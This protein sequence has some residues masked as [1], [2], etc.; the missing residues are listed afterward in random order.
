MKS[1]KKDRILKSNLST[2]LKRFSST[3]LIS[4]L[5]KEYTDSISRNIKLS[6]IFDNHILFR[7][8][9]SE[10]KIDMAINNINSHGFTAPLLVYRYEDKYEV[11]SSREY[12]FAS[13]RLNLESIPCSILNI[14]EEELLFLLASKLMDTKNSNIIELSLILDKLIKKYGYTQKE[15]ATLLNQSRSQITNIRKLINLPNFIL[16][17]VSDDNISFGHARAL[18]TL[19]G[20][21]IK[22]VLKSIK[23]NHLSVRESEEL[24]YDLKNDLKI[25]TIKRQLIKNN[26]LKNAQVTNTKITLV[27]KSK[28]QRDKYLKIN[29]IDID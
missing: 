7:A 13:I 5:E 11:V 1:N 25:G 2:L 16:D 28:K 9:V 3:D 23:E 21:E 26:S 17:E 29:G 19:D 10:K 22:K 24:I 27:F 18:S 12:Y 4:T 8:K 20:N 15:I 6:S 14:N